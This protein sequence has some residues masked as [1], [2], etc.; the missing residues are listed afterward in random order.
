[1]LSGRLPLLADPYAPRQE[2]GLGLVNLP[3][4]QV[5]VLATADDAAFQR[6]PGGGGTGKTYLAAS[7]ARA[8]LADRAVD[9]VVWITAASQEAV[10]RGYAQA[11]R[12]VGEPAADEG[13][14]PAAARFLEWLAATDQPWLVVL[15]DLSDPATVE[16]WWP[17]GPAGHVLITTERPD[18]C[19]RYD[20]HF[21]RV[22]GFGPREALWYLSEWLRADHDQ[23]TG[24]TDL[25]IEL[26]FLP[27]ALAQA[28]T[29]MSETGLSCRRYLALA[30]ERRPQLAAGPAG[31]HPAAAVTFS[32]SAQFASELPPAGLAGRLLGLISMLGPYGIPAAVLTCRA[33]RAYLA[34]GGPFPVDKAQAWTAVQNLAA[35][36]LV[37]IDA[38]S[39]DRT[40]GVHA[41]VQ[42]LAR[43]NLPAAEREQA[44]RA[45]AD[46]LTE[47]W[48]AQDMPD[49]VAPALRDCAARLREV[50]GATLWASHAHPVLLRA[51]ESLTSSGLTGHAV[52]YWRTMLSIGERHLGPGHA[53]TV[54]FRDLLGAA[55]EVSGRTDEAVIM[56]EDLLSHLEKTQAGCHPDILAARASLARGYLAAD[57]PADAHRLTSQTLAECEQVLG[58]NHPDTLTARTRLADSYLATGQFRQAVDLCKRAL[59]D[60]ERREGADHP[61][62]IAARTSLATAY[63][64]A[65][66]LKDAI[67]QYER[68][69]A[70]RERMQGASDPDTIVARRELAFAAC[71]AEKYAYSVKQYERALTDSQQVLGAGHPLT[72]GLRE[73]LDA[74]AAQ[75]HARHG[76]DLR[77]P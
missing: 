48:S 12:D 51:G 42:A 77:T 5:T 75:A 50:G 54:Q 43:Q 14:E 16:D 18:I 21:V 41:V 10:V 38:D 33:A 71:L 55:Y 56:Y 2:T 40:V 63:R 53:Q 61:D 32:L 30:T 31:V 68:T 17:R 9:L 74:V 29:V 59:A 6:G 24:A 47:I 65:G 23:R 70:D 45:A 3:P 44:V 20:P 22:G 34:G 36:G 4:G 35:A 60:R 1:V 72:Q 57:R 19:Q 52:A 67:K 25:A 26:G 49:G 27:I 11:L 15:D 64:A 62:T 8:H 46:A 13:D 28:A 76:I 37:S 66:K 7:L 39:V 58:V 69:V 73:D